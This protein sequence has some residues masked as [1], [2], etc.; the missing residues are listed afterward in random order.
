MP[1][2]KEMATAYA[3]GIVVQ[4]ETRETQIKEL[5][6]QL[7]NLRKHLEECKHEI[8]GEAPS[9]QSVVPIS[10]PFTK[11]VSEK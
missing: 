5:S 4:I 10:N 8:L 6:E 1:S 3:E 11:P 9:T 7:D 2:L